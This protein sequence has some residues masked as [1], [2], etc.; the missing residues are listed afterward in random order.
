M[1]YDVLVEKLMNHFAGEKYADEVAMAKREFFDR[2]GILDEMAPDFEMKM[3]QFVDWYLFSRPLKTSDQSPIQMALTMNNSPL[4]GEDRSVLE[5]MTK[6][7]HSLF[8][9]I[10]LKGEDVYVRDVFSAEKHVIKQSAITVGFNKDELFEARLFP[11]QDSFQ[12]SKAFCFHPPQVTKIILKEVKKVKKMD[13]AQ[14]LSAKEALLVRLFKLRYKHE[15]YK[16]LDVRE[17]YSPDSK[18]KI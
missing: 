14:V 15:Q 12:F 9:F 5:N 7:I 17:I 8:E 16:H 18:L 13:K 1:N 3:A 10:K 11:V 6:S 2:A 4:S